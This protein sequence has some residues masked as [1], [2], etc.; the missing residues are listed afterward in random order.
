MIDAQTQ[1]DIEK[2]GEEIDLS[3]S[4]QLVVFRLQEELF[5]AP[6]RQVV[7]II[8]PQK[9]TRM[10]RAPHYVNGI[11]NL[12]GQVFPV[13][14]MHKRL[15]LPE[16]E[17]SSKTRIMV[18]EVNEAPMGLVVDAVEEVLRVPEDNIDEAPD[19]MEETTGRYISGVVRDEERMILMLDLEKLFA[20]EEVELSESAEE[21]SS[22][23]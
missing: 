13:V 19:L 7:E 4:I 21:N 10:P 2:A 11:L 15:S 8:K 3:N 20:P 6:I 12:R 18:S 16:S 17:T 14:N 1:E 23:N 9:V 5:A 22:G